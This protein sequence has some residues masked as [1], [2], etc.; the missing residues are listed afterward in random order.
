MSSIGRRLPNDPYAEL[1]A[2]LSNGQNVS[3]ALQAYQAAQWF[4]EATMLMTPPG[5]RERAVKYL[6]LEQKFKM[7]ALYAL[8]TAAPPLSP[9]V[10]GV[11]SAI[12]IVPLEWNF[13]NEPDVDP[14]PMASLEFLRKAGPSLLEHIERLEK[15]VQEA[16]HRLLE[17]SQWRESR[18]SNAAG[19]QDYDSYAVPPGI[20][21]N[22]VDHGRTWRRISEL[23]EEAHR[24]SY[25][26]RAR[27][28]MR[29][30]ILRPGDWKRRKRVRPTRVEQLA[31]VGDIA[32]RLA[33]AIARE[34][35][36]NLEGS[37]TRAFRQS[38]LERAAGILNTVCGTSMRPR[39]VASRLN[40]RP[41]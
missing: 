21:G 40:Q 8:M 4:C 7:E 11:F 18:Y 26:S 24:H 34:M 23:L 29:L 1:A 30:G 39:D 31:T 5:E 16:R 36:S 20:G 27:L 6:A 15:A 13:F 19:G 12:N 41:P 35:P 17:L 28:E 14:V 10:L 37:S 22:D 9:N 3:P 2:G 38:V 25:Y 32:A 33:E